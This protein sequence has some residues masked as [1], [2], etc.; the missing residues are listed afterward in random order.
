MSTHTAFV[1]I[2]S[3]SNTAKNMTVCA[4]TMFVIT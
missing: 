1:P 4:T 3:G 2:N